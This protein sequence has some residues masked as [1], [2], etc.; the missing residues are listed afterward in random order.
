MKRILW[1]LTGIMTLAACDTGD[2][3]QMQTIDFGELAPQQLRDGFLLLQAT[4]S[5]ELPVAF[6]SWDTTIAVIENDR[7]L[8]RQTG[9]VNIIAYQ[10]G[11]D[12]FHEAPHIARQLIIRDW[13]PDKKTQTIDFELPGEW[14]LSR[15][16]TAVKL[17]ATASSGLP[18]SYVL[19]SIT[20]GFISDRPPFY[21]YLYHAGENGVSGENAYNAQLSVIA[22]Q[23]GNDEYNPADN[24]RRTIR[25]IGDVFH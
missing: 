5:S 13:D 21:L 14:K 16:G 22:S 19:T 4:A 1:I 3:K 11:N 18:V 6:T 15:D 12:L 2:G 7:A 8:F 24:V 17:S 25:V 20:Y 9:A 23:I 10:P